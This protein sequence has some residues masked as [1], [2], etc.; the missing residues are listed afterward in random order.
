MQEEMDKIQIDHQPDWKSIKHKYMKGTDISLIRNY[1]AM[2][3]R[4]TAKAC[5]NQRQIRT[6]HACRRPRCRG[7]TAETFAGYV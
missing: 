6:E 5:A 1:R 3:S 2:I 4:I 7:T